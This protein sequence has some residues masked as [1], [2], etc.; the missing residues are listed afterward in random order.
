MSLNWDDLDIFFSSRLLD[1][2]EWIDLTVKSWTLK[3]S[4]ENARRLHDLLLT[5]WWIDTISTVNDQDM[6]REIF[7]TIFWI[8]KEF[9]DILSEIM[10]NTQIPVRL[11]STFSYSYILSD[12]AI[13]INFLRKNWIDYNF[14]KF[15]NSL[16]PEL[17]TNINNQVNFYSSDFDYNFSDINLVISSVFSSLF[18]ELSYIRAIYD[19]EKY[20]E[21]LTSFVVRTKQKLLEFNWIET[22]SL[23]SSWEM[24]MEQIW[25]INL[26][27]IRN[28]V[29]L[30]ILWVFEL[31]LYDKDIY[32]FVRMLRL[33]LERKWVEFEEG[34]DILLL[35][36]FTSIIHSL[37][38]AWLDCIWSVA[39][40]DSSKKHM[41]E[42]VINLLVSMWRTDLLNK[43]LRFVTKKRKKMILSDIVSYR[44]NND[45][46][47]L[48]S[49][50]EFVHEL[51]SKW[52]IVLC[53]YKNRITNE[54][55][56]WISMF[57]IM[58]KHF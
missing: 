43:L 7:W 29:R 1:Q 44:G 35:N 30:D 19:N 6:D 21:L 51:S 41:L 34:S 39:D 47:S 9:I 48:F 11:F 42:K 5:F 32:S 10:A 37:D 15:L 20:V 18:S 50:I 13:L 8:F 24:L 45:Y 36:S 52:M 49:F 16:S 33:K 14:D 55:S 25:P 28:W 12:F 57:E 46:S 26:V 53:P 22:S 3:L 2:V 56:R 40:S 38:Q 23:D 4:D 58:K 54:M 17:K 31:D 27:W